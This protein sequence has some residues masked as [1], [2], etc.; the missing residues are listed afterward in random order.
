MNL[1]DGNYILAAL[2]T[3]GALVNGVQ[4]YQLKRMRRQLERLSADQTD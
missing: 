2:L 3:S 4:L 1:A